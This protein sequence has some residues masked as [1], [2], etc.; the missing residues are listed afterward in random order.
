[1]H[2]AIVDTSSVPLSA[3]R[4]SMPLG[5]RGVKGNSHATSAVIRGPHSQGGRDEAM[6]MVDSLVL[7]R[8]GGRSI[9]HMLTHEGRGA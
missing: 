6:I 9:D 2:E 4:P 7:D 3:N 5:E 8:H 1:M